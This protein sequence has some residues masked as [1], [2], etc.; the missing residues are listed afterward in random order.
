MHSFASAKCG[1]RSIFKCNH[2]ALIFK[3]IG[4]EMSKLHEFYDILPKNGKFQ[5]ALLAVSHGGRIWLNISRGCVDIDHLLP[6]G[7]IWH[8]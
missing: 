5:L 7:P 4:H 8:Y 6:L 2:K 3:V 1:S